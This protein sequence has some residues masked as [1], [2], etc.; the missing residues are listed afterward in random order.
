M[1]NHAPVES[2]SK[3]TTMI[4]KAL[5][6]LA[7]SILLCVASLLS[8]PAHAQ[9]PQQD[10]VRGTPAEPTDAA[11]T[12]AQIAV[13]EKLLP[14]Y[15]DR[16]AVLYLLAAFKQHLG[17]NL[18]ALKL[19]KECVAL[20]EG[21]DPSGG[22]EYA[23]LRSQKE[24]TDL[25]EKVHRDFPA[26]A[27]ARLNLITEERNLIPEGLAWDPNRNV[28]YLSSLAQKK[29]VQITPES[30]VSDFVPANRDHLLS[31]LGI[32]LDPRDGSV[33]ANTFEDSGKTELVHFDTS[34]NLLGRFSLS[35]KEKHGFND[36]VIR[37]SGEIFLTDSF[38]NKIFR[39]DPAK[40]IFTP[41]KFHRELIYPNG[42][43][44]SSDDKTIFA[45]DALG[46]IRV[47]LQTLATAD[48]NPGPR[49][50]LAGADGL[51]WYNGSLIAVQNGIGSPRIAAVK[52]SQDR[53]L[54]TRPTVHENRSSFT[55]LPTT[56][57]IRGSDFYFI[58]NSHIDNLN[59][60]KI[61]DPTQLEPVRIA[62][63][64][65]P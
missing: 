21:F 38:D 50:T 64:H 33:W 28:F 16:G 10:E 59:G 4:N 49:S 20:R 48:V 34:G 12:R 60:G 7:A 24:F 23:G 37:P 61:L 32:R 14:T 58:S 19:L 5:F 52:L 65:L 1:V 44:L 53:S 17:E 13:L 22:P 3:L 29:I 55:S 6:S 9:E 40:Q 42:I 36:L 18:D 35:D 43:A 56:G 54:D 26:V 15:P 63:V 41:I 51:Y 39:F 8:A 25:V 11:E 45:A 27:Q 30:R 62:V 57:A 47:D 2:A 31:V 46:V